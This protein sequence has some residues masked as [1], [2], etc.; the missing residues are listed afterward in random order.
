[1]DATRITSPT[2]LD[3]RQLLTE[4]QRLVRYE[5]AAT[6][7]LIASL[8][9]LDARKLYLGE[10]CS[11][12]FTYCTQILHL[13]EHAA[14]HRIAAARAS[15]R[16]PLVLDLLASGAITLTATG[17]LAPHLT[18]GFLE[19]HHVHPYAAG[20][21]TSI[22]NVELRCRAHNNYEKNRFFGLPSDH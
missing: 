20:G 5:R 1:M 4:V 13:S 16:F 18:G 12:L 19:F 3:D 10:G 6:A 14:Y 2:N 17:L 7:A 9:E 11:S 15:R 22:G 8:V 21:E